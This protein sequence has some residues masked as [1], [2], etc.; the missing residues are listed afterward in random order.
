MVE[1]GLL[2][3]ARGAHLE[4]FALLLGDLAE[5]AR[6]DDPARV[7]REILDRTGYLE[8]LEERGTPESRGRIENIDE[9]VRGAEEYA[10]RR[11]ARGEMARLI[12]F[13]ERTALVE[14]TDD[15][16]AAEAGISLLT[17]HNAKGLEYP[18]VF[19]TGL[20]EG[21]FPWRGND[22][23]DRDD[24]EEE[25]R[26]F[27]VGMTRAKSRLHLSCAT[28]RLNHGRLF[29]TVPSR[30]LGEIPAG[31]VVERGSAHHRSW[32]S[33]AAA[34]NGL[35]GAGSHFIPFDEPVVFAPGERVI[36][37]EF[38]AGVV[39]DAVGRGE[40][41]KLTIDF[42]A[43]GRKKLYPFYANLRK[44]EEWEGRYDG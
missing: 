43:C 16:T 2:K 14:D 41:L 32:A 4:S 15:L 38:G 13:L 12:D 42:D 5:R 34:P 31:L 26:L 30:F 33:R 21:L 25:R 8:S 17:L 23:E 11:R 22:F 7:I 20:E 19:I 40:R 44:E 18:C 3:G 1:E 29:Y 10:L 6:E 28:R 27:Y 39:V 37:G 9:F 35:D 24:V 36:H